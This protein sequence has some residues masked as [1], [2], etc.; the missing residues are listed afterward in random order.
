MRFLRGTIITIL[1]LLLSTTGAFALTSFSTTT[2]KFD[3]SL[4]EGADQVYTTPEKIYISQ[5]TTKSEQLS[6]DPELWVK[7]L[8]YY[9][10]TRLYI[11]DLPYTYLLDEN[12]IIYQ[13]KTG[14]LG[15][16]LQENDLD[17]AVLVGYL[18]NTPTLTARA[19]TSLMEMVNEIAHAWGIS[20]LKPV[21]VN[22]IKEENKM[23][24]IKITDA[25]FEFT[26]A[27]NN[28][29]KDWQG[30][31][32]EHLDYKAKIEE[33]IVPTESEIGGRVTVKVKITNE[34][35]FPWFTDRDPIYVSTK[36]GKESS[37]A[38]NQLWPS[39]SKPVEISERSIKPDETFEIGF[40][41]EAKVLTGEISQAFVFQKV[42]GKPFEGSEFEVKFN[43]V[44]GDKTLVQVVS[45]EYGFV[46]VRKCRWASCEILD[47]PKEG[48]IFILLG[49][50]EGWYKIQYAPGVEGWAMLRYFKKI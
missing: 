18:S 24:G 7:S 22:I 12:G 49:E 13:G 32:E 48:T 27:I 21:R 30:Y 10:I 41:V 35:D 25:P 50:E 2:L 37:L 45:P 44:R 15:A 38:I 8:Y 29:F 6:Q 4:T 20:T 17:N 36:D 31:T 23:S 40:E 42:D 43:I 33:V 47:S 28:L 14:G 34:N 9:Y 39:F 19:E 26:T 16:N 5:I 11:P 3:T 46:N 1:L